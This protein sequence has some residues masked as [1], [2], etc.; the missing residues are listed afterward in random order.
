MAVEGNTVCVNSGADTVCDTAVECTSTDGAEAHLLP[1]FGRLPLLLPG[2]QAK[3]EP[4]LR[5]WV[6]HDDRGRVCVP[7]CDNPTPF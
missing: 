5:L 1:Q 6:W 4:V 7:E 3:W 2:G